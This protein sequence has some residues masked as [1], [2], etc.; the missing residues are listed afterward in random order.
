MLFA[1]LMM[2]WRHEEPG[3]I[4]PQRE[5]ALFFPRLQIMSML[6]PDTFQAVCHYTKE[7]T[8]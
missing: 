6:N 5:L 3:H 7:H 8:I 1:K 4:Q 2:T